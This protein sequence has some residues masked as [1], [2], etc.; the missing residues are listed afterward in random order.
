MT[1]VTPVTKLVRHMHINL[2]ETA[3]PRRLET[4][5]RMYCEWCFERVDIQRADA[6]YAE[7]LGHFTSCA[8]RPASITEKQID[9]LAHH[10]AALLGDAAEFALRVKLA[11]AG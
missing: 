3:W 7:V 8:H 5:V 9:G 6:P 1:P 2:C 10:I 4:T 11:L